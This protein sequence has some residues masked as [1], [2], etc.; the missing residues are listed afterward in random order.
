MPLRF[1]GVFLLPTAGA[2]TAEC[3]AMT[4]TTDGVVSSGV[5]G[6]GQQL[7]N[8]FRQDKFC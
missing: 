3:Y 1:V 7:V 4:L 6:L 2:K 5:Q 8:L